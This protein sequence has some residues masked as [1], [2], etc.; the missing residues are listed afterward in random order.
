MRTQSIFALAFASIAAAAPKPQADTPID[1]VMS[2][3]E[4][5]LTCDT[6]T[7]GGKA[8]FGTGCQNRTL[9]KGGSALV[10]VSVS[11]PHGLVTGYAEENCKGEV[12]VVFSKTDGC[13]SFDDVT[14]KS[15]IGGAP[16]DENGK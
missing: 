14:V 12:L 6:S 5:N 3:F 7:T 1:F 10:R 2:I 11:S 16:F 4:T 15:W 9:P 13:T 8:V